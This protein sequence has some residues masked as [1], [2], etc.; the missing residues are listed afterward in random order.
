MLTMRVPA[1]LCSCIHLLG[2]YVTQMLHDE[3]PG[4]LLMN[5][6]VWP[7]STGEVILQSYNTLLSIA[8]L[9]E[10]RRPHTHTAQ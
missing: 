8:H 4:C 1:S 10:V 3:F 7:H 6:T 2:A 9:A 5:Q